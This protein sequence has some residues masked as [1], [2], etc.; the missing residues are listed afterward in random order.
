MEQSAGKILI[1]AGLILVTIGAVIFF[2]IK[3][4]LLGKLPG[5][6]RIEKENFTLYIPLGTGLL[7][8]LAITALLW[9]ISL[10][11]KK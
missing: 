5:D 1:I 11:G 8:S 4:P 6:I 2:G 9:A 10:L 3:I 7:I